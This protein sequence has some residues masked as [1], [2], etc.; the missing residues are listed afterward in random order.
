MLFPA[1]AYGVSLAREDATELSPQDLPQ[2]NFGCCRIGGT[3]TTG[4]TFVVNDVSYHADVLQIGVVQL[5]NDDDTSLVDNQVDAGP[6]D[7]LLDQEIATASQYGS[8]ILGTL[9]DI[10]TITDE[11]G[12]DILN[13]YSVSTQR[14]GASLADVFSVYLSPE[15]TVKEHH[16]ELE[17]GVNE[18]LSSHFTMTDSLHLCVPASPK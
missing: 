16:V 15:N 14:S 3:E 13:Q 10:L 18:D 1:I 4:A 7:A 8:K 11:N 6:D 9:C 2:N 17:F 5:P 12:N